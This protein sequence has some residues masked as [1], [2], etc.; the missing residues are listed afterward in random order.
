MNEN[1]NKH[2]K[3]MRNGSKISCKVTMKGC[4]VSDMMVLQQLLNQNRQISGTEDIS[5]DDHLSNLETAYN[6]NLMKSGCKTES[7]LTPDAKASSIKDSNL[8]NSLKKES[9]RFCISQTQNSIEGK[10]ILDQ[11]FCKDTT[12]D[13]NNVDLPKIRILETNE[14]L[15][16]LDKEG[17]RAIWA[18]LISHG[19]LNTQHTKEWTRAEEPTESTK[20]LKFSEFY[21]LK[22][23][24]KLDSAK[25]KDGISENFEKVFSEL[26]SQV[27]SVKTYFQ[28]KFQENVDKLLRFTKTTLSEKCND[29][30]ASFLVTY[31][32]K[33]AQW[34]RNALLQHV[35]N[36]VICQKANGYNRD[37]KV[38]ML[39]PFKK[40]EEYYKEFL[41]QF[42]IIMAVLV[43]GTQQLFTVFQHL[44]QNSEPGIAEYDFENLGKILFHGIIYSNPLVQECLN[45]VAMELP[46]QS[47]ILTSSYESCRDT[48]TSFKPNMEYN[49]A[50]VHNYMRINS[51]LKAE[52]IQ[53]ILNLK[54]VKFKDIEITNR[55]PLVREDCMSLMLS[56]KIDLYGSKF[57][58]FQHESKSSDHFLKVFSS[59]IDTPSP[60]EVA[61][62]NSSDHLLTISSSIPQNIQN[63][64]DSPHFCPENSSNP[65][66]ISMTDVQHP[67]ESD[68]N[69][70]KFTQNAENIISQ[71]LYEE[72][73]A[74]LKQQNSQT[75]KPKNRKKNKKNKNKKKKYGLQKKLVQPK[76]KSDVK[77]HEEEQVKKEETKDSS[78]DKSVDSVEE[79][80]LDQSDEEMEEFLQNM[81]KEWDEGPKKPK[82]VPNVAQQCLEGLREKLA[83][84]DWR[85]S[86]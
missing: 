47:I 56:S 32:L 11:K 27:Y 49:P 62:P 40:S 1:I 30:Y 46:E 76:E 64:N 8:S 68:L 7:I 17:Y 79:K 75:K 21:Y 80:E 74:K 14:K 24:E 2:G 69:H 84:L 13:E 77:S 70:T 31:I 81:Q 73:Q 51:G 45:E 53:F 36:L 60:S 58:K 61:I 33:V 50:K 71:L 67:Q 55:Q 19:L 29:S 16:L 18:Q 52:A 23:M 42:M 43:K 48:D 72:E 54:V 3:N 20:K 59:I 34:G 63:P 82:I 38:M 35:I 10:K 57:L 5:K 66:N 12:T 39:K 78:V 6:Q 4:T 86:C 44:T 37:F 26:L 25:L 83:N 65:S 41:T 85:E 22:L 15:S 28:D 9:G